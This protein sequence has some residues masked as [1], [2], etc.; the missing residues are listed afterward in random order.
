MQLWLA[1]HATP[2]IAPGTC[3]GALDM[4][5]EPAHTLQCARALAATLPAGVQ[6][7]HSPQR[8][9]RQLAQALGTLRPDLCARA[10]A[11]LREMDFGSWEGQP[12][13]AIPGQALRTWT[14]DFWEHRPGGGESVRE[15]LARVGQAWDALQGDTLWITHAGVIRATLLVACGRRT[16]R[17]A[18]DWPR[19]APGFGGW[20]VI[21]ASR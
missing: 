17:E 9:C 12:W 3:Y 21:D 20:C 10:D 15:L 18:A 14:D 13:E 1:R 11:R 5:A 4:Q 2:R 6:V 8:R 19:E 7:H 16:V